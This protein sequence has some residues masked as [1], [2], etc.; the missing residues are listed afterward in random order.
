MTDRIK[1]GR[2]VQS[3]ENWVETVPTLKQFA[4]V[5]DPSRYAALP[6]NWYLGLS[7]IVESTEAINGG[8]YKAINLAGAATISAVS[9]ALEGDL[10]LFVF[11]GDGAHFAIPPEY[12]EA[13][14]TAL[15]GVRLWAERDLGLNLRVAMIQVCDV[16]VSGLDVS[17]AFWQAS[18]KVRYAMF[19]GGGFD[20]A[21]AQM[22]SN[23]IVQPKP[24][25]IKEPDLSGLS[26]Q[27]GP[28]ES[29][30]GK[31]VSLILKRGPEA[32]DASFANAT[33]KVVAMLEETHSANPISAAGPAV[34][35]PSKSLA[36]QSHVGNSTMPFWWRKAKVVC[37]A[38]IIWA[39]FKLGI[40]VGKFVPDNY[41]AELAANTDY[42]KFDDGLMLTVD[43]SVGTVEHLEQILDAAVEIGVVR[44][45]I[46]VQDMALITCVAPSVLDSGHMHF[47]DGAEGGYT[48][49]AK[50]LGNAYV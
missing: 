30:N 25:T 3:D 15:D 14:V 13:A 48:S 7:D 8:E 42:R 26:C 32:T 2:N 45:G 11:G 37:T 23:A 16:R 39:I 47:V 4:Q 49:A 24:L 40:R 19:S 18:D 28:V 6:D 20:W 34:S 10:K 50:Q 9:N 17:V 29:K 33:S 41:R 22:K 43:C 12:K 5:G 44:Y 38:A 21:E 31:I 35:W 27:W 1:G 36:L 46:H